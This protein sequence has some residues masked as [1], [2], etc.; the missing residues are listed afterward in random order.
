MIKAFLCF[1]Y[2]NQNVTKLPKEIE[3]VKSS[4]NVSRDYA[5]SFEHA[6]NSSSI[7]EETTAGVQE[8][9][10]RIEEQTEKMADIEME[11]QNIDNTS[12]SLKLL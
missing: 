2:K 3:I 8:N 7:Y 1:F 11:F 4:V 5:E 12:I 10:N 9:I 6:S